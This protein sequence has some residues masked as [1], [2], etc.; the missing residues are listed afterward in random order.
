MV[1]PQWGAFGA[2]N[3][4]QQSR[5][6]ARAEKRG[7]EGGGGGAGGEEMR[8]TAA[9]QTTQHAPLAGT[10]YSH[11]VL[12]ALQLPAYGDGAA[13]LGYRRYEQ[14]QQQQ[15]QQQLLLLQQAPAPAVP[16]QFQQQELHALGATSSSYAY[17]GAGG[18]G[19]QQVK[20][21]SVGDERHNAHDG[22]AAPNEA[23]GRAE[24]TVM[25]KATLAAAGAAGGNSAEPS[26]QQQRQQQQQQQQQQKEQQHGAPSSPSSAASEE[27]KRIL[28]GYGALGASPDALAHALHYGARKRGCDVLG[29]CVSHVSAGDGGVGAAAAV[30]VVVDND[31]DDDGDGDDDDAFALCGEG[32]LYTQGEVDEGLAR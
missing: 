9:T 30:G 1:R 20:L 21:E 24:R 26:A 10:A 16:P 32:E 11:G 28:V 7:R 23:A 6:C 15:Q 13:E 18:V 12:P 3:A 17:A 31:K 22:H 5:D 25:M 29:D 19:R 2:H 27:V 4:L 8:W 14:Q